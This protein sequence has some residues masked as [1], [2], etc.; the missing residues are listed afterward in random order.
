[1]TNILGAV[2]AL[3]HRGI[4]FLDSPKNDESRI[5]FFDFA[6]H[7]KI[8]IGEVD[9]PTPGLALSPD[10][11]SLLYSRNEFEDCEIRLARNFH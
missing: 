1:V 2:W 11:K 7:K 10:G 9:K 4:Y 5:E 8:L 6:T 3:S